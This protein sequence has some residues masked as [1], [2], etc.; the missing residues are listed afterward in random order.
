MAKSYTPRPRMSRLSR[1]RL[2]AVV[3]VLS[4][5]VTVSAAARKLGL[6]RNHFQTL[7][8][9][10]LKAMGE[11]LSPQPA[12]RPSTSPRERE[13]LE[14][15]TRVG[16]EIE[17]LKKRVETVDRILVLLQGVLRE[18]STS[19]SKRNQDVAPTRASAR[20]QRQA[21]LTDPLIVLAK[22]L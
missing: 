2:R 10:G 22:S 15:K 1:R 20:L 7:M 5:K 16:Q 21:P 8:H 11:E 19:R 18:R 12:R 6:S 4:G 14:E 9:R 13:L 3:E 17:R